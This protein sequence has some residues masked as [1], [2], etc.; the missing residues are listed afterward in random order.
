MGLC[1][2]KLSEDEK[3]AVAQNREI[4]AQLYTDYLKETDKVRS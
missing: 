2:T 1:G 4:D 3:R